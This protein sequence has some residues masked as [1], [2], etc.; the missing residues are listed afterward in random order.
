MWA[1]A[2]KKKN[3]RIKVPGLQPNVGCNGIESVLCYALNGKVVLEAANFSITLVYPFNPAICIVLS[4]NEIIR[5]SIL[6][7]FQED[8]A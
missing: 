2:P 5:H 3:N 1:V 8:A 4:V 7:C 6:S